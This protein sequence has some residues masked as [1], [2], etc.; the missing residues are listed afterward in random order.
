M[1]KRAELFER[2]ADRISALPRRGQYSKCDLQNDQFRMYMS[3]SVAIYYAP[4]DYINAEAKVV[5]VGITPGWTQ[6]ERAYQEARRALLEGA[7]WDE[8]C[9]RAKA[10]AS[11]AG[12]MRR[13]LSQMLDGIDLH[14]A[15]SLRT[16]AELFESASNQL[17]ATSALRYPVF[18]D[19]KNYSGYN[20]EL[21]EVPDFR[22]I[23]HTD[24]REELA[25][26]PD[27]LLIPLGRCANT[28]VE[29]LVDNDM[30]DRHR[31]LIGFPHPSGLNGHRVAQFSVKRL[32]L[33]RGVKEW[34]SRLGV[35][36][37]LK[38]IRIAIHIK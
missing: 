17:H 37:S 1:F 12:S 24:L 13:N 16:S 21:L 19:G 34:F 38:V 33:S 26:V 27:A 18:V 14:R 5:L 2:F 15:L 28:V 8:V 35:E 6:M 31:C 29:N 20:P 36:I 22:D 32:E 10:H 3:G 25:Q 9:R 4:F 11:F 30:L 7:R 23:V